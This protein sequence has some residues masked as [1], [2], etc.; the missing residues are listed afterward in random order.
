[1]TNGST[2]LQNVKFCVL[3]IVNVVTK[4]V[5]LSKLQTKL[6]SNQA[7]EANFSNNEQVQPDQTFGAFYPPWH[8]SAMTKLL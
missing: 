7:P 6:L 8:D 3:S 1:M 4:L 2:I 5:S